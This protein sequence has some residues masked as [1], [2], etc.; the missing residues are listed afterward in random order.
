M[1]KEF[2][3]NS[4]EETFTWAV[5]L[6][7]QARKGDFFALTGD[8]GTGK[9]IIA[10]GIAQGLG[11]REEITSPTF[12]LLEIYENKIPFY[13]FDLYRLN[14]TQE[15]D[16]LFF[17]EYWEGEGVS[18]VEWAEKAED[19]LPERKIK[20]FLNYLSELERRLVIEYFNP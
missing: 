11:I 7:Q 15:L 19:R 14:N 10:K 8:L 18:V 12:N 17:E 1:K 2:I 9:T 16:Q 20:I 4:S 3:T 6:G 13:H 5:K